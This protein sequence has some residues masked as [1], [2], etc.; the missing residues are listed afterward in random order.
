MIRFSVLTEA[1]QD[2]LS[3]SIIVCNLEA[4][5]TSDLFIRLCFVQ[6]FQIKILLKKKKRLNHSREPFG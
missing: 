1:I 6:L 2:S 3:L 4:N 5:N